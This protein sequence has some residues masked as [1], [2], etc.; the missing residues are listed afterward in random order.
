[1]GLWVLGSRMTEWLHGGL[2]GMM[3]YVIVLLLPAAPSK[4]V[5][6]HWNSVKNDKDE[7]DAL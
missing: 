2:L 7:L 1:M 5:I 4:P 3:P 6:T